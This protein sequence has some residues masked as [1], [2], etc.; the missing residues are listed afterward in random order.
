MAGRNVAD[1]DLERD[2]LDLLDEGVAV[3][4]LLDIVRRDAFFFQLLH[5]RVGQLVVHNALVTDG[6]LLL[7]VAGGRV[8]LVVNHDDGGIARRE[9]LLG[10]AFVH[11]I[12]NL[13]VHDK[14]PFLVR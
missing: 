4:E 1:D 7:A 6:A 8:V 3:V 14:S 5:Q 13:D 11:L 2:D 10:L 9:N 12:E